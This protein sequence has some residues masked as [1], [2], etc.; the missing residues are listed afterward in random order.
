[1]EQQP[2]IGR[3]AQWERR[4]AAYDAQ[5]ITRRRETRQTRAGEENQHA[6]EQASRAQDDFARE[7]IFRARSH[8]ARSDCA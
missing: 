8:V 4:R 3:R 7:A 2:R 5:A 6:H 1:V